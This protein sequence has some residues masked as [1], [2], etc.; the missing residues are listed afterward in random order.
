MPP[1]SP[2]PPSPPTPPTPPTPPSPPKSEDAD[3]QETSAEDETAE[4]R[5]RAE[6]EHAEAVAIQAA[7]MEAA[8]AAAS[9]P[10]QHSSQLYEAVEARHAE[11]ATL[12]VE[13]QKASVADP[14]KTRTLEELIGRAITAR[15]ITVQALL[16]EWDKNRDG[17]LQ[18][19]EFKQ[20]VNDLTARSPLA[21]N[22]AIER[23]FGAIDI[24]GSGKPSHSSLAQLLYT[25]I[26]HSAFH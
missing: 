20:A 14:E 15:G 17:E 11:A 10:L 19:S 4:R 9:A 8:A 26:L 18:M 13:L 5:G 1:S 7:S 2:A 6:G 16:R 25:A 12:K 3:T 23:L 22:H 21:T 24:D